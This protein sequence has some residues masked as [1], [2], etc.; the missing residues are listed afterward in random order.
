MSIP[1]LAF[2]RQ[3]VQRYSSAL[4]QLYENEQDVITEGQYRMDVM[5]P[6]HANPYATAAWECTLLK[7]HYNTNVQIQANHVATC[8][9][10]NLPMECPNKL[11]ETEQNKISDLYIPFVRQQ[12]RH[13]LAVGA[14]QRGTS[15]TTSDG[16]NNI[17]PDSD[18]KE[19]NP[20]T[21]KAKRTNVRFV[22][23]RVKHCKV[24]IE[25]NMN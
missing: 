11:H 15:Q 4:Q 16:N 6:E 1:L 25:P 10:L 9:M 14:V 13:P 8:K 22:T 21:T 5:D 7:F 2:V 19:D 20:T 12:K 24:Q 17:L 18:P 3:L 23:P